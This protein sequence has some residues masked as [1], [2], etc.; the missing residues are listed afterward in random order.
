MMESLLNDY[1][2]STFLRG[3]VVEDG[4]RAVALPA[5]EVGRRYV[6]ND[7][8]QCVITLI[9]D[10]HMEGVVLVDGVMRC[11]SWGRHGAGVNNYLVNYWDQGERDGN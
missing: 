7:G 5:F 9:E 11:E 1:I 3:N 10:I 8:R 6:D 2:A 4:G